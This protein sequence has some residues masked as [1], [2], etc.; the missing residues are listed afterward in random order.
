MKEESAYKYVFVV[1][2]AVSLILF[3]ISLHGQAPI[4]LDVRPKAT[5][6]SFQ[7]PKVFHVRFRIEPHPDN[8]MWEASYDCGN[9]GHS[10]GQIHKGDLPTTERFEEFFVTSS[11][12]SFKVCLFRQGKKDDPTSCVRQN[13][14]IA[15]D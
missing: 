11:D 1:F 9:E 4:T 8:V 5:I 7:T 6:V 13:I 14:L 2:I 10:F 15:A 3:A 12:C